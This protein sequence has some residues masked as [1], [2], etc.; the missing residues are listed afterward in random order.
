[1]Q[2]LHNF[3]RRLCGTNLAHKLTEVDSAHLENLASGTSLSSSVSAAATTVA[4]APNPGPARRETQELV[5]VGGPVVPNTSVPQEAV[6]LPPL[7]PAGAAM[8]PV[9]NKVEWV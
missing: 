3:W 7:P 4:Q 5:P 6:D 2:V 1:M 8:R 9:R